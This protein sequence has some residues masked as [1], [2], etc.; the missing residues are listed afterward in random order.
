MKKLSSLFLVI[1]FMF[2]CA[3]SAQV[4]P[5][6]RS[7][8][9]TATDGTEVKA[10]ATVT[11]KQFD[12]AVAASTA[13]KN[14]VLLKSADGRIEWNGEVVKGAMVSKRICFGETC[15]PPV[16]FEASVSGSWGTNVWSGSDEHLLTTQGEVLVQVATFDPSTFALEVV[17]APVGTRTPD[18]WEAGISDVV[19]SGPFIYIYGSFTEGVSLWI[20]GVRIDKSRITPASPNLMWV[21][22]R[23]GDTPLFRGDNIVTVVNGKRSDSYTYRYAPRNGAS[24][25]KG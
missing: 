20:N 7:D 5:Q 14:T 15:L 17:E 8:V 1:M 13:V 9:L 18:V 24:C 12:A 6:F 3:A 25:C 10:S 23:G 4:V 22:T 16:T 19:S 11:T 2:A 21:D